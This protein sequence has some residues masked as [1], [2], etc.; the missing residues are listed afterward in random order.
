MICPFVKQDIVYLYMLSNTTGVLY[1][2]GIVYPSRAPEFTPGF[3]V[4]SVLLIFLTLC[5]VL[6]CVFAFLVLPC[7][8]VYYG[9][10]IITMF[11]S[12]LPPVVCRRAHEYLIY[13]ICVCLRI[14]VPNTYWIVFFV[15]FFFVLCNLC[16]I[17]LWIVHSWLPLWFSLT[18][19]FDLY[20][21]YPVS[22]V[23]LDCPF[24]IASLV[25][26]NGYFR[27]V[28]YVPS[29]ACFSGLSIL[30]CPFGFL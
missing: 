13:V 6:L 24:L 18:V 12:S 28:S 30:D 20:L 26:S 23:S 1:E 25:F 7:C 16:R 14:V 2:A 10:R 27:P 8:D 29:V 5:V 22:P 3:F 9:F 21:M 17:F 4:G 11:S 15:L 19:I